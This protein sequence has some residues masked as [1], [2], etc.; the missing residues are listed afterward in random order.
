MKTNNITRFTALT[1]A[2]AMIC[3]NAVSCGGKK[4]TESSAAKE[5]LQNSYKAEPLECSQKFSYVS[6][7]AYSPESKKVY[8]AATKENEKVSKLFVTDLD[9][10]EF[11]E[12][13]LGIAENTESFFH[14]VA[15]ADGSAYVV[16]AINDYGDFEVPDYDDPDFDYEKFDFEAMDEART[17]TYK[18]CHVGGD[19]NIIAESNIE[20]IE[21]HA[22]S[23]SYFDSFLPFGK[24]KFLLTFS[25]EN[26]KG[27]AVD[28]DGKII[29]DVDIGGFNWIMGGSE[30]ADGKTVLCGYTVKGIK[31]KYMD[32]EALKP[33]GNEIDLSD[34]TVNNIMS[35][36]KGS[37]D[38]IIYADT[39]SGLYGVKADGSCTEIINWTD[40]DVTNN[41]GRCVIPLENGEFI[42]YNSE[43]SEFSRLTKRDSSEFENTKVITLAM[44]FDD[45]TVSESVKK[46]NKSHD[47]IRIKTVNYDKYNEYDEEAGKLT[48][49]AAKQL[50]M[51]IVAGKAP[52]MVISYGNSIQLSL[53]SKGVFADMGTFL[54]S[55]SDLSRD[56]LMPNVL[57]ACE[58][59]G[60]LLSLPATFNIETMAVKKKFFDKENWTFGE[61]KDTYEKM[62][63]DTE[64]TEMTTRA[65][66][67]YTLRNALGN[68][69]DYDK[70]TCNF[71]TDEFKEILEFCTQFKDDD[72]LMDWYN[73]ASEEEIS[74]Y[75]QDSQTK[76]K[77]EKALIYDLYLSDF[78][79]YKLAKQG[80]FD[81][82]ITLVGV[83]TAD[84]KGGKLSLSNTYSILES[85]SSKQ[86]CWEFIKGAFKEESYEN[87]SYGFPALKSAFDK[88]VENAEK[89]RTY[90]DEDGEEH[91]IDDSFY[92]N[93]K[94]IKIDPLTADEKDYI[95]NYIKN[96]DSTELVFTDEIDEIITDCIQAYFKKEKSVDETAELIN[97]KVSILLS[98]QS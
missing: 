79:D 75:F 83:P 2:L 5:L 61:L 57:S 74:D 58:V 22:G 97:S 31:L 4:T 92:I 93:G 41:Y 44:L 45:G 68:C 90:T 52:D 89:P 16:A 7:I 26:S 36:I 34:N 15:G 76:Y 91:V 56:D 43:D 63:E 54:D 29:D 30:T 6:D 13:D 77:D 35:I 3:G 8:V 20:N 66:A 32:T 24:D 25:G 48:N 50:K 28:A 38:Y 53:A 81:D 46:F 55:D 94:E 11:K 64:L 37:G 12:V 82:D 14:T 69:I 88:K 86:E 98:E 23:D 60:K 78:R 62:P 80:M 59:N 40:S 39:D 84:G 72:E 1:M 17:T 49:S 21:D 65:G 87:N 27:I 9:F 96:V 51:D 67:F 85:S 10:A 70:G 47:D 95:V 73:T 18:F 71:N 42:I 33:D 19:G